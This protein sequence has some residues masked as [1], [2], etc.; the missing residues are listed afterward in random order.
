MTDYDNTNKG[1]MFLPFEDWQLVLQGKI[2]IEGDE[3]RYVAVRQ[4]LTRDGAPVLMLYRQVGIMYGKGED[5]HEKAP[6][7][8][9]KFD[10]RADM[11]IAGWKGQKDGKHYLQLKVS[12]AQ[13][14]SR[15]SDSKRDDGRA[16]RNDFTDEEIPF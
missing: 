8:S 12:E 2:D 4:K 3:H 9:G 15:G 1:V 5:A 7:W 6:D 11:R 13:S 16:P 14:N 10:D